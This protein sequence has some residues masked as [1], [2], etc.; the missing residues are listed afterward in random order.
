MLTFKQSVEQPHANVDVRLNMELVNTIRENRHILKC[1]AQSILYCGRQCIALRG[2]VEKLDQPGNP[3]NFLSMLKMLAN[4][5]P[6]LKGHLEKPR[7]SNA[8][9]ISP[10]IQNELIDIIGKCIIQ[11]SILEEI[12]KAKFFSVM[13]DEVTSHNKEIMPLCIRFV[14]ETNCI[15]EEFIHFSTLVRITGECI[16]AQICTD[17]KSLEL[18]IK[19]VR[20]Q[21]YDGASSMS[22]DRTGCGIR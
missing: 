22:S 21:G 7:Q 3:G 1:C 10:R 17:L 18:D 8:T 16:A 12:R 2:D 6:I 9:Y 15:R 5:D 13:V 14:D 19:Y 20:G 11:K 4:Y